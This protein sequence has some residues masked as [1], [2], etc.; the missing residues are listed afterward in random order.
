MANA[1]K[2][3]L[4]VEDNEDNQ[5]V[6]RLILEHVGYQVLSAWDGTAGVRTAREALPDL[7]L[8]DISMPGIDG[9]E[10]TRILKADD[11]A[12]VIPI[13]VLTAHA[14]PEDRQLA[15]DAGCDAYVCKPALPREVVAAVEKLIGPAIVEL[16]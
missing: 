7:V 2:T 10:A 3:V 14:R 6:D 12:A 9:L 11:H 1:V 15:L 4:L 5:A 8:M 16:E 13:I